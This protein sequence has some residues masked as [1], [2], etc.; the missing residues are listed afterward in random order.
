[1]SDEERT[2]EL[3]QMAARLPFGPEAPRAA[4][5]LVDALLVE[6][7]ASST[8][9]EDAALIVHELVMNGV[10]HGTPDAAGQLGLTYG[11]A[12]RHLL[13]TVVDDG[14]DGTVAM[15]APD[16]ESPSGRGLAI[17]DALAAEWSVDRSR[18]TSVSVRLEL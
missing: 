17:V 11:I 9:R 10:A 18:G 2:G 13:V 6:A 8:A 4:R 1:M 7:A 3:V 15:R 12:G 14:S 5:R 16:P